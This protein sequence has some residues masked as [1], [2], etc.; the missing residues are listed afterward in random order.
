MGRIYSNLA[1]FF[2]PS[3]RT[4]VR[5]PGNTVI[6]QFGVCLQLAMSCK[7][8]TLLVGYSSNLIFIF[9]KHNTQ[10]FRFTGYSKIT[11]SHF[12][13][14]LNFYCT[15]GSRDN[16][17]IIPF[18]KMGIIVMFFIFFFVF[19]KFSDIV[20]GF[21]NFCGTS[22]KSLGNKHEYLFPVLFLNY[23]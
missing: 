19:F 8:L 11:S 18:R 7:L 22:T 4:L 1:E 10:F 20:N 12:F 21:I 3:G 5:G 15:V 17:F 6:S 9:I 16:G 23:F 13:G 2:G 14:K